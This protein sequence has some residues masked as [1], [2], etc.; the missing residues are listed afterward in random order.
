[1]LTLAMGSS[2]AEFNCVG[3][4]GAGHGIARRVMGSQP[5]GPAQPLGFG[6]V[7]GQSRRRHLIARAFFAEHVKESCKAGKGAELWVVKQ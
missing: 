7:G 4:E 2:P 6:G 1:M 5:E 3:P